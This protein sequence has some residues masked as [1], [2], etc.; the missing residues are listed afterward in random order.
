MK[1]RYNKTAVENDLERTEK[2]INEYM[3]ML[4]KGDKEEANET[5]PNGKAI[6][7]AIEVLKER[8]DTFEKL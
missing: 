3:Q 8:K 1:K 4:E 2:K 7:A 6:K 5:E